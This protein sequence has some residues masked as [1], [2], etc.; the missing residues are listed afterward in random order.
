MPKKKNE[1]D[2]SSD[3]RKLNKNAKKPSA[4]DRL[5]G[6]LRIIGKKPPKK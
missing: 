5:I 3:D 1:P 2:R 4:D 6:M